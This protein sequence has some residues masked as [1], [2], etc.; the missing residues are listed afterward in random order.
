MTENERGSS[1]SATSLATVCADTALSLFL[2]D[3]TRWLTIQHSHGA[4][5]LSDVYMQLVEGRVRPE[6]G[7]ILSL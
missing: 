3:S 1:E 6:A 4:D 7:H 2:D 5:A